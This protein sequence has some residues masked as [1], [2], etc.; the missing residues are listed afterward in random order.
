MA[1]G[2]SL[3]SKNFE[4]FKKEFEKYANENIKEDMLEAELKIDEEINGKDISIEAIKELDLLEPFGEANSEPIIIYKNLKIAAIRTLSE[5]KHLKLSL[6]DDNTYLD[7]IG[8][9]LGDLAEEYQIGDK[10]DVVG[11]IQI[12]S[13]NNWEKVQIVLKDLRKSVK[14]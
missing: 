14:L 4:A 3:K 2:L 5:G 13:F 8:F 11:N 7:A 9:N 10:I 1:I 12:N 6:Q